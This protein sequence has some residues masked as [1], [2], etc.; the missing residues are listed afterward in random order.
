VLCQVLCVLGGV[1]RG[2]KAPPRW[3]AAVKF[4]SMHTRWHDRGSNCHQPTRA[5]MTACSECMLAPKRLLCNTAVLKIQCRMCHALL[6]D[7]MTDSVMALCCCLLLQ[8]PYDVRPS[9]L[10]CRP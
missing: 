9:H 1:A 5:M 3:L 6:G 10:I 2:H 7:S 8:Q 4:S